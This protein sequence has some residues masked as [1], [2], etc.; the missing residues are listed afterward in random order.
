MSPNL[1]IKNVFWYK[2]QDPAARNLNNLAYR[3]KLI[4]SMHYEIS[5]NAVSLKG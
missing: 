1:I 3:Q 2:C 4:R 5:F